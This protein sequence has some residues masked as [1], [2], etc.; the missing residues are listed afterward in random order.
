VREL[1]DL[2]GLDDTFAGAIEIWGLHVTD[3]EPNELGLNR[4]QRR[5]PGELRRLPQ[6]PF[7]LAE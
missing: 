2:R 7:E 5:D 6:N 4:L 1:L 3:Y